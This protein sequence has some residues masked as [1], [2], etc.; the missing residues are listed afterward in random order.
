MLLPACCGV[1]GC[2]CCRFG[3]CHAT[4]PRKSLCGAG[5]VRLDCSCVLGRELRL[6]CIGA[7]LGWRRSAAKRQ[8]RRDCVAGGLCA[9]GAQGGRKPAFLAVLECVLFVGRRL[10]LTALSVAHAA[11]NIC[12]AVTASRALRYSS[13]ASGCGCQTDAALYHGVSGGE[14]CCDHL[15]GLT[16]R[17]L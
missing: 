4:F 16:L 7:G 2:C 12:V 17:R 8:V 3:R 10:A 13:A 11:A 15:A 9:S 1:A 14:L 6:Q 5:F